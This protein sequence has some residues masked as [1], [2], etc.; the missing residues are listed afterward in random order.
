MITRW[1]Y[2]TDVSL[3]WWTRSSHRGAHAESG[4]RDEIHEKT[5]DPRTAAWFRLWTFSD[6]LLV[7]LLDEGFGAHGVGCEIFNLW[8]ACCRGATFSFILFPSAL[9]LPVARSV[10]S[11]RAMSDFFRPP[12]TCRNFPSSPFSFS[13][14]FCYL[15]ALWACWIVCR[16]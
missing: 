15:K 14:G 1:G 11:F 6:F 9:G 12:E 16:E 2:N 8:N 4:C 13:L 3:L 5:L 7:R 10:L